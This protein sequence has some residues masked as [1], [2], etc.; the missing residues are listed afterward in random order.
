MEV[1]QENF[2]KGYVK[3]KKSGKEGECLSILRGLKK[4]LIE[5]RHS[6]YQK[7][8]TKKNQVHVFWCL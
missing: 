8:S 3:K 1:L 7:S 4:V 5:E 2:A 6:K